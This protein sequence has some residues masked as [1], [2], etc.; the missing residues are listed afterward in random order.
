[1]CSFC[2]LPYDPGWS[3]TYDS[4]FRTVRAGQKRTKLIVT[5]G[6]EGVC[7]DPGKRDATLGTGV[8][9]PQGRRGAAVGSAQWRRRDIAA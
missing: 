3:K 9:A 1:M 4:H 2:S 5:D 7:A 6:R 8:P